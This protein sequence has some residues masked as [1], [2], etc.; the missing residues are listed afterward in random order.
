MI[1]SNIPP[2]P[3][4]V[5]QAQT[6]A[7]PMS[8]QTLGQD[9]VQ[10]AVK[11]LVLR[12]LVD[13]SIKQDESLNIVTGVQIMDMQNGRLV[14]DHNP[15][16]EQFAAS[17]NKLP[18]ALLVLQDLRAGKLHMNQ[19]MTWLPSD[20]RAGNGVYD[21]PGAPTTASFQDVLFDMLNPSGN[22]AVRIMVNYALGGA[23]AVNARWAQYP[24]LSHTYLQPLDANRFYLGNSTPHDSLWTLEKLMGTQDKYSKFMKNALA[25]NIYTDYG[26]RSQLA[27]NDWITLVNKVGILD[28]PTGD[29]RHDV[30]IIY[31]TKTHKSYAYSFMLTAPED[32][33]GATP[34]AEQSLMDMGR[35][36]LRFAGDKAGGQHAQPFAAQGRQLVPEHKTL[37]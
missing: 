31:N 1:I 19:T 4:N 8:E 22:T 21:Q 6:G 10:Q 37:Y 27:G 15:D 17:V 5:S 20:V 13:G 24:Q 32:T 29:N 23:A 14:I 30:G 2:A 28:D 18:V 34:Q 16:T 11:E 26:V 33:A 3:T 36:T 25:T 9:G 35:Y 7:A 12:H